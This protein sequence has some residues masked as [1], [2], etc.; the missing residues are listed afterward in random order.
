LDN[1]D[2][3]YFLCAVNYEAVNTLLLYVRRKIVRFKVT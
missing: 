3:Q 1:E 2:E